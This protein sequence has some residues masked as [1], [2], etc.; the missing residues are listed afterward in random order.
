MGIVNAGPDSFSD[1]GRRDVGELAARALRLAAE[2]ASIIDVGGES[3]RTDRPAVPERE[4]IERVVPLVERL[5][6]DG[7]RVSVDTWRAPVAAR[8]AGRRRAMINDVSALSDPGV[9][10]ACAET[11]A[12]LVLTHTRVPPKQKGFPDYAD[13]MEDVIALLSERIEEAGRRGVK[14]EQIVLDPGLDLAKTPAQSV[15][16][17]R[18]LPE[19]GAL[20]YPV[21]VAASR[22][23]F[24]GALT[25]RPP[26]ERDAGTL[27][28]LDAAVEGGASILRV[29]D[30]AGAR[31][32]LAVRDAAAR[33]GA[34]G[35]P[36]GRVAAQ[37]ARRRM[38][39]TVAQLSDLHCGS[40]HFVPSLLERAIVEVNEL[41]PDV[42]V[43]S[44]DLTGDGLRGEYLEAREAIDG[45]ACKRLVVIPGN[46]D[47]RNVGYV[48]FEELFGERRSELHLDGVSIVAV[49]ST[50]PDLDHGV[51]GRGR[52]AW[53]EERFATRRHSCG[54][55]CCTTTCCRCRAP[56]ASATWSTTRATRS[57]AC[58]RAGVHLVLSGHKHV[59][60]AWRLENLFV[61]NAGTVST[62][63]L[64]G[65]T[66]PC[67][68]V[69]E[70]SP[71]RVTVYRK[72]P[73]HERDAILSFDPR[74]YEYEKDQSLLG[75]TTSG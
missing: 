69:I 16:L 51:I 40:P 18:R 66:K 11:G 70:A 6:R 62:T 12:A 38:S 9:A 36:P 3:G 64:R 13:V 2:G 47:S 74:T 49:D 59:P 30:V 67:Y 44:G 52:Y 21:L 53:I 35:S 34:G 39:F 48:H 33:G 8:G 65:K 68:N 63:R 25:G 31:D 10:D 27:A 43:I 54:S 15:E 23:D 71:E 50:E 60:Y 58:Q 29:H 42:V 14:D 4:E 73:F 46:H 45:I 37:G 55:S 75:E 61:V 7:L 24:V 20:G 19:L 17:L 1:P 22:K 41:E 56:G 72:Y 26:A 5:A 28:A 57:S 32:Y